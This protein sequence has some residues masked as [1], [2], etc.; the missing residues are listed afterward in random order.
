M[1]TTMTSSNLLTYSGLDRVPC[2]LGQM[3]N[4]YSQWMYGLG[5]ISLRSLISLLP[6]KQNKRISDAGMKKLWDAES[7]YLFEK[8]EEEYFQQCR[9]LIDLRLLRMY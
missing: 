2:P 8:P 9:F 3:I 5:C 6:V 1:R 7:N 4:F